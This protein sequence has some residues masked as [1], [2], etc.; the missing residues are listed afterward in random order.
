MI[1]RPNTQ[2]IATALLVVSLCVGLGMMPN[3]EARADVKP[4][5]MP[6]K[7]TLYER[8]LTRP[9]AR[10]AKGLGDAGKSDNPLIAAFSR[11]YVYERANAA[12][13]TWIKIGP[14][15]KGTIT[16][17]VDSAKTVPWKQQLTLALTN[18][19]SVRDRLLFFR[20]RNTLEGLVRSPNPADVTRPLTRNIAGGASDPRVV[21]V[22]PD[23]YID[24]NERF[25]LLPVLESEQTLTSSG[26]EVRI[27]KIAS[28]SEADLGPTAGRDTSASTA[29]AASHPTPAR[30]Y[31]AAIVFV[32]DSTISMGPYIDETKAAITR[33]YERLRE[34]GVLDRVRFGLVAFR[35]ESADA[36][37]NRNLGYVS[38]LYVNPSEVSDARTF[39]NQVQDLREATTSTDYFDE[40]AFA[41]VI[42]A[43]DETRWD[44]FDARYLI[45]ITDAGALDGRVMKAGG[46][47][48]ESTTGFDARR[49]ASI[50][51]EKQVALS[52]F[53]LKSSAAAA[54]HR[55]A[56]AQY[57][58]LARNARFQTQAYLPITAGD[59]QDF[60]SA[61]DGLAESVIA[62]V[63]ETSAASLPAT[64]APTPAQRAPDDTETA[65]RAIA[66]A[67][68]HAMRLRY[69]G[70]LSDIRTP[71][72]FEA[73]ISDRD[74]ADPTKQTVEVR[75]LLTKNE[76]SDLQMMLQKIVNASE[77]GMLKPEGFF[78][79]LRSLAAQ[80]GRDAAR[81]TTKQATRLADL[82]LLGEYLEDLPYQSQVMGLT[83]DTWTSWGPEKQIELINTLKRKLRQYARYNDDWESWVNLAQTADAAGDSV[84]PV[85]LDDMP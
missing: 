40:D 30:D 29:P 7:T 62:N 22:E 44:D 37:R 84:Y 43:L 31:R 42:T 63:G 18:P 49:I 32:I 23:V 54:G 78:D 80:F 59:V 19:G 17:W 25:Y 66:N 9:G 38:Q 33:L 77:Q 20:D 45:L 56:E 61:V 60:R 48:V 39:L 47:A 57:R 27:L 11:F 82:G 46:T 76:L 79:S 21:A 5:L 69:L 70:S 35:A 83:Q 24:I 74:F 10:L 41:G 3:R 55:Y 15:V 53:H 73:W 1:A 72:L 75:V 2:A 51:G 71:T 26:E 12:G 8:V 65:A 85:P 14:D 52:V 16:G 4:L 34:A 50:A 67:L 6:G 13:S 81:G 64:P 68:G 58:D 36:M 28:V